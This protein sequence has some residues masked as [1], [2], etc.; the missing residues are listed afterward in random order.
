MQ[1][2]FGVSISVFSIT[3]EWRLKAANRYLILAEATVHGLFIFSDLLES[4][5]EAQFTMPDS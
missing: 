3:A 2:M 5:S 1:V 4:R